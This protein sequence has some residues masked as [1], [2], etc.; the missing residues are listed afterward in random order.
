MHVFAA[1]GVAEEWSKLLRAKAGH[2]ESN[3]LLLKSVNIYREVMPLCF[4]LLD[5]LHILKLLCLY[6]LVP[7]FQNFCLLLR[8]LS[9][10]EDFLSIISCLLNVLLRDF[11]KTINLVFRLL[12]NVAAY[13][14][15]LLCSCR[16]VIYDSLKT[17]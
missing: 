5:G 6:L 8:D 7:S 17:L 12:R 11:L 3:H 2:F 15:Y 4:P 1:T 10:V 16:E 14:Y 13:L 9:K